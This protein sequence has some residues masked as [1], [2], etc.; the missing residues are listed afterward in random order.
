[1]SFGPVTARENQAV[2][3][4]IELS[5]AASVDPLPPTVVAAPLLLIT[6]WVGMKI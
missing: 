3:P 4:P 5:E 2:S 1:M 6:R